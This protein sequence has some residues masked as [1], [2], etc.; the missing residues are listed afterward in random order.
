[1]KLE[2]SPRLAHARVQR[3]G[4]G[5][6]A[7]HLRL[8]ERIGSLTAELLTIGRAARVYRGA[9]VLELDAEHYG[10]AVG[11]LEK[12]TT[13]RKLVNASIWRV[14]WRIAERPDGAGA[15]RRSF[16][17]GRLTEVAGS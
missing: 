6:L 16:G 9:T 12:F 5:G 8:A 13:A 17:A 11:L 3:G 2:A 4:A 15:L 7:W 14:E 10:A 1:M